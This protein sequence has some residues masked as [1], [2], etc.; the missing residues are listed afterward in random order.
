MSYQDQFGFLPKEVDF[1]FSCGEVRPR[2]EHDQVVE[3]WKAYALRDK[4]IY[5]PKPPYLLLGLPWTH[6]LS[7]SGVGEDQESLR[8]GIG[9]FLIQLLGFLYGYRVQFHHWWIDGRVSTVSE[10]PYFVHPSCPIPA[11]VDKAL[12]TW[13][14]WDD[15][16]QRVIANALYLFL[17]TDI[18]EFMWERFAAEYMVYDAAFK[19]ASNSGLIRGLIKTRIK[20]EERFKKMA[21]LFNLS[22]P[23]PNEWGKD[24]NTFFSDLRNDLL[25][26]VRWDGN[27]MMGTP[28]N[29]N[30]EMAPRFL[31]EL[32]RRHLLAVLG[33]KG[34]YLQTA[35]WHKGTSKFDIEV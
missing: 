16:T 24:W 11:C 35:W 14:A 18:Y 28:G 27:N 12:E 7:L 29:T 32:T 19:V 21:Q 20:H 2:K 4:R 10:A 17:R 15:T 8:R 13:L 30:A 3:K 23:P 5:P 1:E 22:E 33:I 31:H 34:P 9:G 25:H 26:E 6:Y